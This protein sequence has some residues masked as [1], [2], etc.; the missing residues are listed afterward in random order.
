MDSGA[1][2]TE[3][4]TLTP[5][6]TLTAL[7][8]V[9]QVTPT[10]LS[11]SAETPIQQWFSALGFALQVSESVPWWVGDLYLEGERLYGEL[12]AQGLPDVATA[13]GFTQVSTIKKYAWVCQKL[14][15]PRRLPADSGVAFST[16]AEVAAL[17]PAA[18][19][20]LLAQAAKEQWTRQSMREAVRRVR[21]GARRADIQTP[22]RSGVSAS[23]DRTERPSVDAVCPACGYQWEGDA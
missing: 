8:S 21:G 6:E 2:V 13:L 20:A 5:A 19:D 16:Q 10:G 15:Q 23:V 1:D 3:S 9:A 18:Q 11:L 17:E 22:D 12:A 14:P 4:V 7:A